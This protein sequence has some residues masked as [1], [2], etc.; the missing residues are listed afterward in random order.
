MMSVVRPVAGGTAFS[1]LEVVL[2]VALLGFC[3]SIVCGLFSVG[4]A[5][6]QKATS[7]TAALALLES[8]QSDL[9]CAALTGQSRSERFQIKLPE[10]GGKAHSAFFLDE[11]G[12]WA[13]A[14]EGSAPLRSVGAES[15]WRVSVELEMPASQAPITGN[16]SI[17]WPA[18]ALPADASGSVEMFVA[19]ERQI[20]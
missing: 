12:S 10:S 14:K 20:P 6:H 19:L 15:R 13:G 3:L 7:Q 18:Q 8:I 4:M 11:G 17:S 1:L 9:A 16:V 5:D 2:A